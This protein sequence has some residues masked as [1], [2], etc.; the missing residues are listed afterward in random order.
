MYSPLSLLLS[1]SL[2]AYVGKVIKHY[3]LNMTVGEVIQNMMRKFPIVE[4]EYGLYVKKGGKYKNGMWL[5]EEKKLSE[6]EESLWKVV[7][8]M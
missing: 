3:D 7:T 1:F 5:E 8:M 2:Y 6:F 4:E